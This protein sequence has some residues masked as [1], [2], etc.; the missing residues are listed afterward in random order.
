MITQV[1]ATD[2]KQRSNAPL[3]PTYDDV[4]AAWT[5]CAPLSRIDAQRYA[6]KLVLKFG[7]RKWLGVSRWRKQVWGS[8]KATRNERNAGW[9]RM[10]HDVGHRLFERMHPTLKAHSGRH[11]GFELAMIQYVVAQGWNT[12]KTVDRRGELLAEI[13]RVDALTKRWETKAARAR[14]ALSKYRRART[15]LVRRLTTV[16][17]T[18]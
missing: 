5:D 18:V 14:T 10:V 16:N 17:G 13:R 1:I 6:R 2:F 8:S 12:L 11:A 7:G 9:R 4:N 3:W 15:N